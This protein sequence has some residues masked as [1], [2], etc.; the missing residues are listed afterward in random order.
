ME[1]Q[2]HTNVTSNDPK[3]RELNSYIYDIK[4]AGLVPI[5]QGDDMASYVRQFNFDISNIYLADTLE[6]V[7]EDGT[8]WNA[9]DNLIRFYIAEVPED[10]PDSPPVFRMAELVVNIDDRDRI[11][12]LTQ[13]DFKLLH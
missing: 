13:G 11:I 1:V 10:R 5:N 9:G 8:L 12:T 7:K 6:Y 2:R 4:D 3:I